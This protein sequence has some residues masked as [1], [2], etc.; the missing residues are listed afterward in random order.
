MSLNN[1]TINTSDIINTKWL[2][3]RPFSCHFSKYNLPTFKQKYCS[4][5]FDLLGKFVIDLRSGEYIP[6][7]FYSISETQYIYL[8]VGNFSKGDIDFLSPVYLEDDIG[9]KYNSIKV[10]SGDMIITRSGT[11]GSIAIFEIPNKLDDK[12]FIPS[13]HLAIIK[14]STPDEMLFLKYYLTFSF[15]KNFFDAFSTGKVQKEI[16]NWSIRKIP[17]PKSLNKT[18]LEEDFKRIDLV[19]KREQLNNIS[20]QDSIDYV[21]TK[22]NLKSKSLFSYR[23]ENIVTDLLCIAKNKALRIGS[24]Y[25]DFW[26]TH[27]GQLFKDTNESMDLLPL[28]RIIKLSNKITLKKGPLDESRALIDF[29]QVESPNGKIFDFENTVM[30]LGSD[31]IE[32]GECDFLT[33]KLRPY[34]GYTILNI[35]EQR[36]IGTTEFI[37]FKIRDKKKI[38]PEYIR[39]LLLSKEYLEK[40]KFLMSG[41]EHPRITST[42]IL[43][44]KVPIP[45]YETQ[46][47]IVKEIQDREVQSEKARGKIK[48]LRKQI[49]DIISEELSNLSN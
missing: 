32:F 12:I 38:M 45:E 18:K 29:E 46:E 26:L 41:K 37:P 2:S 42:D 35:T 14:T 10:D 22:Y 39:Y 11:V 40:S 17:I 33:N 4:K 34:L 8:N 24:E 43:N 6:K 21:F 36:L 23:T 15:C 47:Q 1:F 3:I 5:G 28:K 20:L 27:K 31:R 19:I 30:E 7:D 44:I 48:N 13:H 16:T 49:D 9:E 25:N